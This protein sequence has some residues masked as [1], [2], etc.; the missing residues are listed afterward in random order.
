VTAT[1][2]ADGLAAG[3]ETDC[4]TVDA[5]GNAALFTITVTVGGVTLKFQ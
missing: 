4:Y 2:T 5:S 3:T 1:G